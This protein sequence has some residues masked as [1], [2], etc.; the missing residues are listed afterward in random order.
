MAAGRFAPLASCLALAVPT[1]DATPTTKFV[2]KRYHYALV[3]PGGPTSWG[4]SSAIVP[5]TQ[6]ELEP[7]APQFDTLTD[8]HTA[9][10]F[11]IGA[12]QLA[13]GTTLGKW[14]T[15]FLSANALGCRRT[16]PI[17]P[18]TLGGR[19]ESSFVFSC[20]DGVVGIGIDAVDNGSGYFT[21]LSSR[22]GGS[23]GAAHRTEFDT[24]RR[25]FRFRSS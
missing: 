25:S 5:W 20:G 18:S 3:L 19:P 11:I 6:G 8:E 22:D 15:Y 4:P 21:V 23:V 24:V 12:R 17:A 14:T 9:R 7:G 1:A 2:S 13:S 10:F 16:S